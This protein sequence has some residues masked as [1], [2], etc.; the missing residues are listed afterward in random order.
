MATNLT[1]EAF[2]KLKI[3]VARQIEMAGSISVDYF[4]KLYSINIFQKKQF[5]NFLG[6]LFMISW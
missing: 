4:F 1:W 2:P 6:V 3:F 5:I